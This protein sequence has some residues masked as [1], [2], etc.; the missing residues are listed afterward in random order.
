VYPPPESVALGH[1][2]GGNGR[3]PACPRA[4]HNTP[5]GRTLGEQIK[6]SR[7]HRHYTTP[8]EELSKSVEIGRSRRSSGP[9]QRLVRAM[10]VGGTKSPHPARWPERRCRARLGARLGHPS[11]SLTEKEAGPRP[12]FWMRTVLS[13]W[14]SSVGGSR[15]RR[16][17]GRCRLAPGLCGP[18]VPK[19]RCRRSS[20]EHRRP[21]LPGARRRP[22]PDWQPPRPIRRKGRRR[23]GAGE[24]PPGRHAR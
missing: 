17:R 3:L 14:E 20:G 16:H 24:R 12:V 22:R 23:R 5:P 1:R 19:R 13:R 18:T 9:G 2:A 4:P 7:Q 11:F 15:A 10:S 8:G 6:P 21:P